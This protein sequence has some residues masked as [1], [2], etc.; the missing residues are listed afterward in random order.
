[1]ISARLAVVFALSIC[2]GFAP[3]GAADPPKADAPLR[4]PSVRS[5]AYSP[6]G[7]FLVAGVG[8]RDQPGA[9]VAWDAETRERL[10]VKYG[11]KGFSSVSF[12][13]DGKAV[14]VAHGAAT[15]MRLDPATGKELGAI[16]P[17]H[18]TVR[19]CAHVPGTDLI[20][21]GSDGVIRLWDV[22]TGK[23]AKELK[24]GHPAEV[25]SLVVSPDGKWL[26]STGPDGTRGWDVT[27]GTE[28]K[29]AIKQDRG[30]AFYGMTF[31]APDRVLFGNNS[32][33]QRVIEL[34]SGKELLK[35]KGYGGGIAYS[36]KLGLAAFHWNSTAVHIMDLTFRPPS[37]EETA[38]IEKLLKD[39]DD[40]SYEARLA[41][42]KAMREV[43]SVAEP[44]LRKAT[45]DGPSAEVR[46]RARETRKA[47]LEE[48]L[49]TLKG[50]TATV[51]PMCFSPDGKV[52]ATGADD[53]TVRLWDPRTGKELSRL[54]L[55]DP[56]AGARP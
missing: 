41:A 29:D 51:V 16:G 15:A 7:K 36:P 8:K 2:V 56:A 40:D 35:Y 42:S 12:A 4:P 14:A 3:A 10:W 26:I 39:F 13:P 53:G 37:A 52:L 1:M 28:L 18:A 31:V 19:A 9:V 55:P 54:D 20:A 43:G 46:M 5:L 50:H 21:T 23:V 24:G 44:L 22:K 17:H 6:D 47:I 34:P 45:A 32:A 27:T 48:P 49:L 11:P 25:Y 33:I 38:R 30:T